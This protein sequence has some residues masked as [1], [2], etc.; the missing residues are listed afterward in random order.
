MS[1]RCGTPKR[2]E[3]RVVG[4]RKTI[5]TVGVILRIPRILPKAIVYQRKPM[6][7]P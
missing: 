7:T 4:S 5:K 6:P 2:H 1:K 3:P